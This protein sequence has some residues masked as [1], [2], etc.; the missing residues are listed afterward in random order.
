MWRLFCRLMAARQE[1]RMAHLKQDAERS[2][3]RIRRCLAARDWWRARAGP[4][5]ETL[6]RD[7]N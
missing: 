6:R 4:N 2:L 7:V 1:A 3:E 5:A